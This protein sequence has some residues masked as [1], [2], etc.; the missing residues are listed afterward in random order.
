MNTAHR[1]TIAGFSALLLASLASAQTVISARSGLVHY[2]EGEAWI[3]DVRTEPK[4]G[5]FPEVKEKSVFRTAEGRAEI[6]MNS[7]VF[8]RVGENSSVRMLSNRLIDTRVELVS[9]H[10]MVEAADILPDNTVTLAVGEG[11]A[12]I[13]KKGIYSFDAEP[14]RLKVYKGES[15]V[16]VAGKTIE[17][18]EGHQLALDGNSVT[19]EK[20]DTKDTDS[21]YRWSERRSEYVSIANA[22]AAHSLQQAGSSWTTG[23]WQYNPWFGMFTFIPANGILYSPFGFG[24]FSPAAALGYYYSY[25]R[26][27][28]GG[29]GGGGGYY[30]G[31]NGNNIHRTGTGFDSRGGYVTAPRGTGSVVSHSSGGGMSSSGHSGGGSAVSSGSSIGGGRVGGGAVGGSAGG[32]RGR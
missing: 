6:L 7:G 17:V 4:A 26:Y 14:A 11:Q 30:A 18:K 9:G 28:G 32:G 3:D 21:L 13:A 22:S 24:F 23:G 16:E 15:E 12:R 27:W 31:N 8:L 20:F 1:V 5:E 10:V 29:Y 19:A 25:P 2:V